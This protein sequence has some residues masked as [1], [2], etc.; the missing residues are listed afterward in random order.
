M[1]IT[2]IT[3]L[4]NYFSIMDWNTEKAFC[5]FLELGAPKIYKSRNSTIMI[6]IRNEVTNFTR[7]TQGFRLQYQTKNHNLQR[8]TFSVSQSNGL[9]NYLIDTIFSKTMQYVS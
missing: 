5:V 2:F 4:P 1:L 8:Y 9:F 7:Q 3:G 6:Y